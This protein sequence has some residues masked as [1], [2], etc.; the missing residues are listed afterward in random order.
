M[1]NSPALMKFYKD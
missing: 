1:G